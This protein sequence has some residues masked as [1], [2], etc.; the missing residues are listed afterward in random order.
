MDHSAGPGDDGPLARL[1]HRDEILQVLFW[2]GGEGFER[3]MTAEGVA[4]FVALAEAEV[5]STLEDMVAL[6]LATRLGGPEAERYELTPAG[7]RE[8]GR[9]FAEEFA[10]MF[11][12]DAHGGTCS[13][14]SCDCHD[15]PELATACGR[16]GRHRH[17]DPC[18]RR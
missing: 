2:L 16:P 5:R 6:G 11:A 12:R 18:D 4:R 10:P 1:R 3:D 17:D 15:S 7:R 13:D 14:P 9:R 8:G